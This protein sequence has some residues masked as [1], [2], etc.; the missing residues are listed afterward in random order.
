MA[1]RAP[2][3]TTMRS[4]RSDSSNYRPQC[5]ISIGAGVNIVFNNTSDGHD[6]QLP[7][8]RTEEREGL[9]RL[10]GLSQGRRQDSQRRQSDPRWP[11]RR[12]LSVLRPGWLGN[13]C[14]RRLQAVAMLCM[15]QH[16][17][18]GAAPHGNE[19]RCGCERSRDDQGRAGFLQR[20]S[21]SPNTTSRTP[22][23]IR[24]NRAGTR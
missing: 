20:G 10:A 6:L 17:Q 8:D 23:R 3:S 4:R 1:P 12:R 18:W 21:P 19:P 5:F 15:E 9:A 13:Q 16:L 2:R 22:I 11:A 14:R 24:C 7:R